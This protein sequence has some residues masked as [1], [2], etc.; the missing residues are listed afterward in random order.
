MIIS[1]WQRSKASFQRLVTILAQPAAPGLETEHPAPVLAEKAYVARGLSF[2]YPGAS[3][4][5]FEGLN[6]ELKK[7]A[8]LGLMGPLGSGKSTLLEI[9][10]GLETR[11][12][13]EL[14]L[15]IWRDSNHSHT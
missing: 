3:Y 2:S 12:K 7:G 1:E 6:L 13:G 4:A 10:S 5:V 11:F 8:R 14:L 15:F 9:F